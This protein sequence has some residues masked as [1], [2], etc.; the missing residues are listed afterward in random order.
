MPVHSFVSPKRGLLRELFNSQ[1]NLWHFLG[2]VFRYGQKLLRRAALAWVWAR[3]R[4]VELYVSHIAICIFNMFLH[5]SHLLVYETLGLSVIIMKLYFT[6]KSRTLI[7]SI[8]MF[9]FWCSI[10]IKWA[11][12]I[13]ILGKKKEKRKKKKSVVAHQLRP[14]DCTWAEKGI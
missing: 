9:P 13:G 3:L 2:T 10:N 7:V 14:A 12:A 8:S 11:F 5:K 4:L 6:H 1:T